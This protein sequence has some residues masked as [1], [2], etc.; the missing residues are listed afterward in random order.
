MHNSFRHSELQVCGPRNRVTMST[1]QS[2][3]W[4]VRHHVRAQS[5]DDDETGR[6]VCRRRVSAGGPGGGAPGEVAM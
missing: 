4:W 5:N 1:L 2:L 6:R 3:V